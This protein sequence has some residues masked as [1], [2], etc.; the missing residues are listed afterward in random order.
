MQSPSQTTTLWYRIECD[1]KLQAATYSVRSGEWM[2]YKVEFQFYY[3]YEI[4][5]NQPVTTSTAAA[6]W[7][8]QRKKYPAKILPLQ[9]RRIPLRRCQDH[10]DD[11]PADFLC[12]SPSHISLLDLKETPQTMF[13]IF[14]LK[15]YKILKDERS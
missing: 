8:H 6:S 2:I 13:N 9:Q 1:W 15:N 4:T 3:Y 11:Q 7:E 10:D 5:T 14:F 12:V